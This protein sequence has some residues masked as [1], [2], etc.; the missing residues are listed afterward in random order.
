MTE[1]S[2]TNRTDA[3]AEEPK[4]ISLAEAMK[5][6]LA[7]KKQAQAGGKGSQDHYSTDTKKMKS[8]INKKPNNQKRR[9]GV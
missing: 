4:K 8:Q 9:T 3:A 6:K 7:A 5:M 1:Q 2:G